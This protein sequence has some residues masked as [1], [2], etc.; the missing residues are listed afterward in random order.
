MLHLTQY[1]T[2]QPWRLT[3][4]L[5]LHAGLQQQTQQHRG[6]SGHRQTQQILFLLIP[7][8]L[9]MLSGEWRLSRSFKHSGLQSAT[10]ANSTR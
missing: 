3:L 8:G 5:R 1:T 7:Q 10:T 9:C 6:G 4:C 2:E